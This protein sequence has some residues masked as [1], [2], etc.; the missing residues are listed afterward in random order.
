MAI[1]P[2]QQQSAGYFTH[3]LAADDQSLNQP[4]SQSLPI[5]RQHIAS[6]RA[7]P[8]QYAS[9]LYNELK[10]PADTTVVWENRADFLNQNGIKSN[11]KERRLFNILG[12]PEIQDVF[13]E[14]PQHYGKLLN[15][16]CRNS[17]MTGNWRKGTWS[18]TYGGVQNFLR[19]WLRDYYD[20]SSNVIRDLCGRGGQPDWMCGEENSAYADLT[21]GDNLDDDIDQRREGGGGGSISI[22]VWIFLFIFIVLAIAVGGIV[23]YIKRSPED[24]V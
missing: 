11:V 23:W 17:K 18:H 14:Y 9:F 5:V 2:D 19:Q 12:N 1:P 13:L 21:F 15:M 8:A 10:L 22:W 7:Y 4:N 24:S 20:Y 3:Q 6:M 16:A